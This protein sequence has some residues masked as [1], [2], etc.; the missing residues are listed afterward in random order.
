MTAMWR[1]MKTGPRHCELWTLS[2]PLGLPVVLGSCMNWRPTRTTLWGKRG[3]QNHDLFINMPYINHMYLP[4]Y[5]D[6]FVFLIQL[7]SKHKSSI[8]PYVFDTEIYPLVVTCTSM[9][10]SNWLR[11]ISAEYLSTTQIRNWQFAIGNLKLAI[12]N[13]QFAIDNLQFTIVIQLFSDTAC[14]WRYLTEN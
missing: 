12:C 1:C 4:L 9:T 2:T 7:V 3:V 10:F 14:K 13:W 6:E 8:Q 11:L 5:W